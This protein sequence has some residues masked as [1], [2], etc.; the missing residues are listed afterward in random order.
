MI[1]VTCAIIERE[2]KVL[3]TQRST[4]MPLPLKWEFPGGKIE[5]GETEMDCI[6]REIKEEL[7]ITI[8]VIS[9]LT[10]SIYNYPT[11]AITLIPFICS[12][13][14]GT[15]R[16]RE[17]ANYEWRLPEDLLILDWAE[18]DIPIL[19]EYINLRHD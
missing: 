8:E 5:V 3:V 18:A 7:N 1:L 17:H 9:R 2:G 19:K 13:K 11:K 12:F 15:V 14:D 10:P 4:K 6:S 16:L